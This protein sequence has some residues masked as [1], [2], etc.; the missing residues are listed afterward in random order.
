M[1]K[2]ITSNQLLLNDSQIQLF[3]ETSWKVYEKF[4]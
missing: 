3:E 1:Q 2:E 4:R